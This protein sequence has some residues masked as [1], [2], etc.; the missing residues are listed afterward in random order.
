MNRLRPYLIGI[1]IALLFGLA[2][3]LRIFPPFNS[4][5]TAEGVRF[6]TVDAYYHMY[7]VDNL[8]FNFPKL[9]DFMPYLNFPGGHGSPGI[10][11][12]DWLLAA[13]IWIASL[14]KPTTHIIDVIGAYYPAVLG[15]LT[16]IPVYFMG[17]AV[18]GRW[19]GLIAAGIISV[20]PGEFIGRS[21]LGSTDQHVAETLLTTIAMMFLILALKS[22]KQNKLSFSQFKEKNWS[23]VIKPVGFS[24]LAGFFLGL[25]L[26]TWYGALLFVFVIGLAVVIQFFIDHLNNKS[27]D[28]LAIIYFLS[29]FVAAVMILPAMPSGL[30]IAAFAVI[31]AGIAALFGFSQFMAHRQIKRI[32]YPLTLI[33]LALASIGLI[34]LVAPSLFQEILASFSIF[35][36]TGASLT[37]LEMQPILVPTG[38]FTLALVW[39]NFTASFFVGFLTLMVLIVEPKTWKSWMTLALISI[40]SAWLLAYSQRSDISELL[41]VTIILLTIIGLFLCLIIR[42]PDSDKS[43]LVVWGLVILIAT[44]G[45]RRFAYYFA[46]N[47][48]VLTGY[49]SAW[50]IEKCGLVKTE[51]ANENSLFTITMGVIAVLFLA[52]SVI[53]SIGFL[54]PF[55]WIGIPAMVVFFIALFLGRGKKTEKEIKARRKEISTEKRFSLN[56]SRANLVL[57]VILIFLTVLV[58]NIASASQTANGASFAPSDAWMESLTWMRNN[59]PEPFGNPDY[60]YQIASNT[61]YPASAYGVLSW[62]D[63]GYWI[64][65]IAHR[66]PSVNP[67][68]DAV[69]QNKVGSIFVAQNESQ[70][71]N[72][73]RSLDVKYVVIDDQT[74][75]GKFWAVA[76]WAGKSPNDYSEM[77]Y[78]PQQSGTQTQL[79]PVQLYYPE[80]YQSLL[81]RLFNFNGQA[82]TNNLTAKQVALVSQWLTGNMPTAPTALSATASNS[83][84]GGG[85]N[86][87]LVWS[88]TNI[89]ELNGFRIER[90]TNNG[91][92]N[93]VISIV[94]PAGST[95]YSDISTAPGITYYYR[96]FAYNSV[97]ESAATNS[98]SV[99]SGNLDT[100]QQPPASPSSV[101]ATA[102]G[103]AMVAVSWNDTSANENGFRID[104][105]TTNAFSA[106][107]SIVSVAANTTSWTDTS[108]DGNTTYY[109]RIIAYNAGGTSPASNT[110]SVSVP[111]GTTNAQTVYATNCAS[112]HGSNR[113]GIGT[114]PTLTAAAL[115][116][117]SFDQLNQTIAQGTAKGMPGFQSPQ[118]FVISWQDTNVDATHTVKVINDAQPFETYEAANAFLQSK[119]SGNYRIVGPNPFVNPVP[120]AAIQDYK[121]VYASSQTTNT[122]VGSTSQVKIF[123]YTGNLTQG[124]P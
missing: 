63:Y 60:Y 58:P 104:R 39:G 124:T 81:I 87:D 78:L 85:A 70:A 56:G 17:K 14:G 41:S 9:S 35:H 33:V 11:F 46:V 111:G 40:I 49:F 6:S 123:Q 48:A 93:G 100:T 102:T 16:I 113:E 43:L 94:A 80:Y 31:L 27:T 114:S 3:W 120:L 55:T 57:A 82:F 47:A 4:I 89:T 96:V 71:G 84:T 42:Q 13:V 90:A 59:T 51:T 92:S 7:I 122:G 101:N 72:L 86:I 24:L 19:A 112:C 106:N 65:R 76:T 52:P 67:S 18:M 77:Y 29:I 5:F 108:T 121:L 61:S 91:F 26:L 68:Q 83:T 30:Y 118:V 99:T 28:Y 75:L 34:Y 109:Y 23:A 36:P 69:L 105:S 107:L 12:F 98:I 119:T 62:W 10:Y 116:S 79:T 8:A 1:V 74:A 32:Y 53:P 22:A 73:V 97:G 54:N 37:T 88:A 15:A 95:H 44:I 50:V 117:K 110:A 66:M 25:Y 64:T 20:L 2:L 38:T 45:Q 115:S 21:I 103:S